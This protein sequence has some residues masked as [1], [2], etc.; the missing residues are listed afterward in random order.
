MQ[1]NRYKLIKMTISITKQKLNAYNGFTC[2]LK[3]SQKKIM[4]NKFHEILE[5][6]H[7]NRAL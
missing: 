3:L 1:T 2:G 6:Q 5:V 7:K 4:L